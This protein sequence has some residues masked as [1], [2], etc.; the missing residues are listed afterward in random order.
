MEYAIVYQPGP[1]WQTGKSA[2]QQPLQPHQVFIQWLQARHKF[3][4]GGLF[5][6]DG[7]SI[8]VIEVMGQAEAQALVAQDPAVVSGVLTYRLSVWDD[9]Y[10]LDADRAWPVQG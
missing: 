3:V 7:T 5:R 4:Q 8:V 2:S 1:A 6:R 10:G 9:V